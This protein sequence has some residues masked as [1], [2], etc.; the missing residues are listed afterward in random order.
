MP[1]LQVASCYK[2]SILP[3]F[4]EAM[5]AASS[6]SPL[7]RPPSSSPRQYGG[8]DE[9]VEPRSASVGKQD[10]DLGSGK[11][12][13]EHLSDPED[14]LAISRTRREAP[15]LVRILTPEERTRLEAALVRK[16]DLR[17]L[18]MIV[19]IYIMNYIDR[20]N[21]ASA[22]LQGLQNDLYMSDTEYLTTVSILFVGY[23]LMQV[24]SNLF[25][26]KIGKPALYLPGAM[27]I[28]GVISTLTATAQGFGGLL[29]I[30]F[31]LGFVEAAYF[32]GCLYFLSCWYTRKACCA[33]RAFPPRA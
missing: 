1:A 27:M 4:L 29:A 30:R 11:L 33:H 19:L 9:Q 17:L 15:P 31:F 8:M 26:N 13:A 6:S 21:I 12:A 24:P 7:L 25:L 3:L 28:W 16:V 20:N 10:D 18:P 23:L 32:P 22:R 14:D 5:L 2:S